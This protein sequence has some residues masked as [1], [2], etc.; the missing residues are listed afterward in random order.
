MI[1]QLGSES[2]LFAAQMR[3]FLLG[4]VNYICLRNYYQFSQVVCF[5]NANEQKE[6]FLFDEDQLFN[7]WLPYG[8]YSSVSLSNK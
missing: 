2:L 7:C 6:L 3:T 8:R 1:K 4:T 5:P